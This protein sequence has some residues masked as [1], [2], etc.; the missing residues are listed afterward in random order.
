MGDKTVNYRDLMDLGFKE[1]QARNIIR[2]AKQN[3]V[4][5]G[6]GLYNGKRIG[7]VP[8]S[9]VEQIIGISMSDNGGKS[10]KN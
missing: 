5:R 1:H 2:Q 3:L 8:T 9:A 7:V 4:N 6:L 10:G